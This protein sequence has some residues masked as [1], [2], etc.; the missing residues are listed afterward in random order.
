MTSP[1]P[2]FPTRDI[3]FPSSPL[4]LSALS[5]IRQHTSPSVVNHTLRSS[6][7][8]LLLARKT[9]P[10][11]LTA[12]QADTLVLATMLHDLG[13]ASTKSLVSKD[14]RFEVDGAKLACNLIRENAQRGGEVD[15]TTVW[16]AIALH[17]SPSI[18][19]HHPV[20]L[21]GLTSNGAFADFL[22]PRFPHKPH[23][24]GGAQRDRKRVPSAGV[25]SGGLEGHHVHTMLGQAGDDVR[26]LCGL[27]RIEVRRGRVQGEIR[28]EPEPGGYVDG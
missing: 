17:T 9:C 7:F 8:A 14:K 22:G 12:S 26:Q 19:Q 18:A 6:A 5:Y 23:L 3:T 1:F 27:V 4:I 16:T 2:S 10:V 24:G 28:S 20:P 25:H 21:V 15:L 13:W 11:Q